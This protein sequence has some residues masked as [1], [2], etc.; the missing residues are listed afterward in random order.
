MSKKI[1]DARNLTCPLPVLKTKK[2]MKAVLPGETLE[3]L[4]TDPNTVTDMQ[5]FV[6]ARG[7][8]LIAQSQTD[9]EYRFV[10]KRGT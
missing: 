4:A 6:A 5:A 8:E 3:V 10:L 7:H 9:G 1:L 2:A